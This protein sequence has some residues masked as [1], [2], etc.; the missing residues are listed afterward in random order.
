MEADLSASTVPA[1]I[2]NHCSSQFTEFHTLYIQVLLFF[3][4]PF[5]SAVCFMGKTKG[6]TRNL[7]AIKLLL[8]SMLSFLFLFSA[9]KQKIFFYVRVSILNEIQCDN[10]SFNI[11]NIIVV[12]C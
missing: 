9:T 6:E 7:I 3:L 10:C 4:P 5:S 2:P 11:P 12:L 8:D 1:D